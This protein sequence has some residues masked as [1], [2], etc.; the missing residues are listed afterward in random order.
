MIFD[1][2]LN[3]R[4]GAPKHPQQRSTRSSAQNSMHIPKQSKK[5]KKERR[6]QEQNPTNVW[7]GQQ[8]NSAWGQDPS[9]ME[10]E[11]PGWNQGNPEWEQENT[12][13]D[14]EGYGWDQQNPDGKEKQEHAWN[15]WG[16]GGEVGRDDLDSEGYTDSE[17]WNDVAGRRNHQRTVSSPFVPGPIGDSPYPMRNHRRTV[18]SPFVPGPIGGS[19]HPMS[20]R[21]MAYATATAQDSLEAFSPGLSH[22]RNT[23]EDSG[24]IE[25]LESF[26]EAMRPVENAFFGRE[27]KARDRIHWQFPHDKDD[28]VRQALEWLQ[29]N[30]HGV[31]AFGLTKFLQTRERGALFINAS[32]DGQSGDSPALDWLTY[33]DVVETRDRLLQESVGFYDPAMQV[34]VFVFLPSKTG[35][36]LAMWRRKVPV[37]N[38]V[39]LAHFREID[40]ARAALRKEYTV[41]VDE[42][43]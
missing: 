41:L 22:K 1:S 26:G 33:E 2:L 25:S 39:R 42:M 35:N 23:I 24:N 12:Q 31:G 17:G 43:R 16:P 38:S 29:D 7:G 32:Y 21:T 9:G 14:G 28:R 34:I 13:W 40:I 4:G 18:S 8:E 27:R 5:S 11:N 36:S 20:S 10:P 3:S 19:P 6:A 15:Q 30:A 37:P